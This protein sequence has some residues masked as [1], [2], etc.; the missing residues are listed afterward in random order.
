MDV[1]SARSSYLNDIEGLM[2]RCSAKLESLVTSIG[3]TLDSLTKK[4][5]DEEM[6]E[7]SMLQENTVMEKQAPIAEPKDFEKLYNDLIAGLPNQQKKANE[8]SEA[9]LLVDLLELERNMKRRRIS[10]KNKVHTKNKSHT[11]VIRALV[12][13]QMDVLK[14]IAGPDV[15]D[16]GRED[17]KSESKEQ[18]DDS[19]LI[20]LGYPRGNPYT[21][22]Q[23]IGHVVESRNSNDS[24]SRPHLVRDESSRRRPDTK[25]CDIERSTKRW[26]HSDDSRP[27]RLSRRF[28]NEHDDRF[29]HQR[30]NSRSERDFISDRQKYDKRKRRSPHR[31]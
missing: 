14:D 2:T 11:E 5:Q 3:W 17:N 27:P 28:Q 13:E 10:Y 15:K 8:K 24:E 7:D 22:W 12:R 1:V 26:R 21:T 4:A 20:Q 6:D 9:E 30:S 19:G 16:E 31:V 29:H 18:E 25:N 23:R